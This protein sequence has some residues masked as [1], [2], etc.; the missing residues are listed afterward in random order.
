MNDAS[1][2]TMASL[3]RMVPRIDG[4]RI[5]T[6]GEDRDWTY[7]QLDATRESLSRVLDSIGVPSG[8][9]VGAI[10]HTRFRSVASQVATI[11]L[12]RTLVPFSPLQSAEA[13]HADLLRNKVRVLI[14][15]P[16]DWDQLPLQSWCEEV[17]TAGVCVDPLD[18]EPARVVVP[19]GQLSSEGPVTPPVAVRMMT[20]GTTG[21]P[22]RIELTH[23]MLDA[24]VL[25]RSH[26]PTTARD[27]IR[28]TL[29]RGVWLMP[30][31]LVHASGFGSVLRAV[32]Q[33]RP[34]VLLEKF[35]P[36]AWSDAVERHQVK[37]A[38]LIPTAVRMML[39][40]EVA[41]EKLRSLVALNVG[42]AALSPSMADEFEER[43]GIPLLPYYS[44]T[45][46]PNGLA[47]WSLH[48]YQRYGREK[49]ASVGRPFIGVQA[50]VVDPDS[51]VRLPVGERGLLAVE[52]DSVTGSENGT[53]VTQ[54]IASIDEDGFLFIWG[55]ADDAINRGGFKILPRAVEE[56]LEQHPLVDAAAVVGVPDSRLG[57]VPV[58][59]IELTGP[60]T[61]DELRE[62]CSRHLT[63]YQVPVAFHRIAL[64]RT[65]SMKISK[66]QLSA[67]LRERPQ[68]Q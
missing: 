51:H 14:A 61:D 21:T 53:V 10:L 19:S 17:G 62:W 3:L 40:S 45:E 26:R 48:D 32:A 67:L 68:D 8:G 23:A 15:E 59:A 63:S 56:V 66:A 5:A 27:E 7:A 31:P 37:W 22:K 1:R 41:P 54:D 50:S 28:P 39:D 30:W 65:V 38:M 35:E 58:A 16:D 18:A 34:L 49:R 29:R 43:F 13:L 20:S 9:H 2:V 42:S 64:P 46:F 55:R 11:S 12:G 36:Y 52:S 44:A 6:F 4:N 24:L 60:V 47:S 57:A 33:G 25:P